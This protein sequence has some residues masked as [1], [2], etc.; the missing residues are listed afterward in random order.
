MVH[1]ASGNSIILQDARKA[2]SERSRYWSGRRKPHI[3]WLNLLDSEIEDE[4][5]SSEA[6]MEL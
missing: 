6:G 5:E 2:S 1:G 4:K 3:G